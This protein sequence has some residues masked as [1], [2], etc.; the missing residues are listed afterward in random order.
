MQWMSFPVPDPPFRVGSLCFI[1]ENARK[2]CFPVMC[3][4][5]SLLKRSYIFSCRS[6][7]CPESASSAIAQFL[8]IE[9]T[10]EQSRGWM[11]LASM[12]L[13][14]SGGTQL[15]E[16]MTSSALPSTLVKCL[17][18]FFDLPELRDADRL[19]PDCEFTARERRILLQKVFVQVCPTAVTLL[20][21]HGSLFF[22]QLLRKDYID[23]ILFY[24]WEGDEQNLCTYSMR[25]LCRGN[26]AQ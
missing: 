20:P 1:Y 10:E 16:V 6:S 17:Y 7:R 24:S 18:L 25:Y 5:S 8:E 12:N 19:E 13:L 11:L 3:A 23:F 26:G 4:L 2:Q 15:V 9:S 21:L 14:A 22:P